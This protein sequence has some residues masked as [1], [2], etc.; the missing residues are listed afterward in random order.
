LHHPIDWE[1]GLL[2]TLVT[3]A[4]LVQ[5]LGNIA[6][7]RIRLQPFPGTATVE[8]VIRIEAEENRLCEL[9]DGTLVEKAMGFV[10]SRIAALL[11]AYLQQ[12]VLPRDLGIVLAP[13]GTLRLSA[14]QVRIPDVAFIG[15]DRMP[16]RKVPTT[17]VPSVVPHL[18]VEV[19]SASN[20]GEEMDRKLEEYFTAG[21]GLVWYI[22]PRKK[23]AQSYTAVEV[24]VTIGIDDELDGGAVLPGFRL[25]LKLI[26]P[27]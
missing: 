20:T 7:E 9:I 27:D 10:E 16:G 19:L 12:F 1:G 25:P 4:D 21:V 11:I 3:V 6:P 22:D 8:D 5:H 2:S 24:F 18:A 23:E 13:D 14:E 26:L 15:W 17:A